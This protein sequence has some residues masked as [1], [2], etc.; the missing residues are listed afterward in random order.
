MTFKNGDARAA[1]TGSDCVVDEGLAAGDRV[2]VE[3]LQKIR[4]RHAS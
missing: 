3:G 2:V 4:E 1:Q